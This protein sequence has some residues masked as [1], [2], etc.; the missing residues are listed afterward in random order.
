MDSHI[1]ASTPDSLCSS[2]GVVLEAVRGKV[3]AISLQYLGI[4]F[5]I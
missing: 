4:Q 3:I 2:E 1:Y 5:D